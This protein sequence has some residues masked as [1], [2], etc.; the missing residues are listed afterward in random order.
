MQL[1]AP[2]TP[3]KIESISPTLYEAAIACKAKAVWVRFGNRQYVI[4]TPNGLIGIAF[5]KVMEMSASGK[6][7][8]DESFRAVA[9]G[10]FDEEA[11]QAFERAHPLLRNKYPTRQHLPNYFLQRER[12]VVAASQLPQSEAGQS[13]TASVPSVVGIAPATEQT[14]TSLDGKLKGK[15]D[16]LN[17]SEHEIVDYKAGIV[18]G[19]Q[20][21][22]I[23]DRERRQLSFY[24]YLAR[25]SGVEINRGTIIRSNGKRCSVSISQEESNALA[26]Q[27]RMVLDEYNQAVEAGESFT[28]MAQPSKEA[29]WFCPCIPFCERFWQARKD[30]WADYQGFGWHIQGTVAETSS[31]NL[32]GL[33]LVTMKLGQCSG[34]DVPNDSAIIIQQ[35]PTSWICSNPAQLPNVGDTIRVIHARKAHAE[36]SD[37]FKAD[38]AFSTVWQVA[39]SG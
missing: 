9:R 30:G 31:S 35:I 32:Q 21:D 10:F 11:Q 20:G 24:A 33:N 34:T 4:D 18:F 13:S 6:L 14:L 1:P 22:E 36:K 38:K 37:V 17:I 7:P 27:A 16:W 28:T 5:H 3:T 8:V 19:S 39:T 15:I 25:Q 29:C 26:E 2:P 12:A 23:S